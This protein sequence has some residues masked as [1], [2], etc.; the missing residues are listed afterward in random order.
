MLQTMNRMRTPALAAALALLA[1]CGGDQASGGETAAANDSAA[2][3]GDSAAAAGG[4][5]PGGAPAQTVTDNGPKADLPPNEMGRIMVLEYHRLGTPEGEWYRSEE[6]FR[7]DL[8]TLYEKGYRPVTM[9]QVAEGN[10]DL[11]AGT[12]PVVFTIDDASKGQFYL[13]PDGSI[14][15]NT[16]MGIWEDFRR[17]NE[18][19]RHGAVWC[20]LPAAGHPSNFFGETPDKGTPREQREANIRKKM[21]HIVQNGHE[22]CNHTLFHERLSRGDDRKVQDWIGIGEDSLKAYLPADY[23]IVTFALPLGIWPANKSLAW[24]GSY[25]DGKTYENKVVLEVSGGPNVPP[26]DRDWDP[27]SVDRFIVAPGALERQLRLWEENPAN[28]FVSDGDPNTITVPQRMA[29]R[30]DRAKAGSRQVRVVPD[31]PAQQAAAPAPGAQP[32]SAPA[33]APGGTR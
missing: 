15:P 32:A 20:I 21:E 27:H 13:R 3:G 19:W 2:A 22:V 16:M 6:N 31:A 8:R 18:G 24:R 9:R 30:V 1:A 23:D 11:P 33:A 14:D 25:R 7:K 12:T 26:W 29:D 10:I 5:A 4:Q 17:Q 28:R